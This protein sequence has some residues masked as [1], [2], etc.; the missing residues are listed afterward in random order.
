LFTYDGLGSLP[1]TLAA[2]GSATLN[3]H[4]APS[5]AG[6]ASAQLVIASNSSGSPSTTVQLAGTGVAAA[7]APPTT[8]VA[9]LSV[10]TSTVAF[11]SVTVGT[12]SV[13]PVTLTSSGTAAV[14][15]SGATLSGTGF[16]LSGATTFPLTLNSGQTAT[17][18]LQFDPTVAGAAAGNLTI[19]SN[20][21]ASP[22]DVVQLTGTGVA[23]A[24]PPTTGVP[25]LTVSTSTVAF[26]SVA[27]GTPSIQ[28][29]TL[30][31]SGTAAVIVS[32]ATLS[33]T[34]FTESGV[35][36][37]L[38]LNAGQT[39]TL[40]LQFDPT[41]TGAATGN[42]TI[43]SDSQA[44]PS[45]IVAITGTGVAATPA[46]GT[47]GL[48]VSS[49]TVAFGNVAVGTTSTQSLTL[50][51]S[52]TAAVVVSGASLSGT[53]FS[54]SGVT[55]PLTL[56]AGQTATLSLQFDPA[57]AGAATGT[58]TITSN[59]S[60]NS[61]AITALSGTGVPLAVDLSWTAP[62]DSE[63]A[64][65]NVYRAKGGSSSYSRLNASVSSP[66]SYTDSTVQAGI[67]YQYY[68]TTVDTT[69]AESVPSNTA[70]VVTP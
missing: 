48:T 26:G 57:T 8:G 18:N 16:T 28:P 5:T 34:G 47:P 31:S 3:V 4:F 11:G 69:G 12:P 13:Q 25:G 14:I 23:A 39:A 45:D 32:G 70:T 38:T 52:G 6:A 37:P 20:S 40:N 35:T 21:Q 22:S 19:A 1:F 17:L 7:A 42:L 27:V 67:T 9:G 55:F 53:G 49:S 61:T 36:F 51:S 30:T 64:G 33:G 46:S 15:V 10:S 58:L 44:S 62:S 43:T 29:V 41:V 50:T 59:A 60:S 2:N 68:V 65:F 54:E 56:N 63:I 66:A 24:A